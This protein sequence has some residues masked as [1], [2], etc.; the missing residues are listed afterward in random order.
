MKSEI[1]KRSCSLLIKKIYLDKRTIEIRGYDK[2]DK[3]VC[4]LKI[5][6]AGLEV[7]K[8]KGKKPLRDW[9]WE[10]MVKDVKKLNQM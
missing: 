3:C 8:G 5:N 1:R 2:S 7:F 4:R 6:A 9:T 10:R